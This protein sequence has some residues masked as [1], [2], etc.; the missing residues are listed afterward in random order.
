[1]TNSNGSW[2]TSIDGSCQ[3]ATSDSAKCEVCQA[4][5]LQGQLF[6]ATGKPG[7][8]IDLAGLCCNRL[9]ELDPEKFE[10]CANPCKGREGGETWADRLAFLTSSEA[11]RDRDLNR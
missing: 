11:A 8:N 3:D 4:T 1:M 7:R 10:R 2:S 6:W 5:W 9:A